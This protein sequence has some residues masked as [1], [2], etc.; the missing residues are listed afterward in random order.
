MTNYVP[1]SGESQF[2]LNDLTEEHSSPEALHITTEPLKYDQSR[3]SGRIAVGGVCFSILFSL[4]CIVAGIFI[5]AHQIPVDQIILLPSSLSHPPTIF[6]GLFV[7]FRRQSSTKRELLGLVLNIAVT[8]CTESIGFV[9]SVALKSALANESRLRFNTNLRLLTAARTNN[10]HGWLRSI[11]FN[12]TSLN[13]VMAILLV[14]SYVCSSLVILP[15]QPEPGYEPSGVFVDPGNSS[16]ILGA[17]LVILGIAL[18][19]Q[20]IIA[21][22]G[23]YRTTILTWS[24][25]P[26]DITTALIDHELLTRYPNRCM[27]SVRHYNTEDGPRKPCLRQH[28]AWEAHPSVRKIVILLWSLIPACAVWGGIA[29]VVAI[30]SGALRN[31]EQQLQSTLGSWAFLPNAQTHELAFT[32]GG[33]E[34]FFS[35]FGALATIATIQ[36]V[37]TIGLHCSEVIVNVV[38]DET[39]WRKASS[40]TGLYPSSNPLAS[41][42]GNWPNVGLLMAKPILRKWLCSLSRSP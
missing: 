31:A 27:H 18:L 35:W 12:G 30:K 11:H 7:I 25:S 3:L 21:L 5:S 4:S 32:L 17:P 9:H 26:F 2:E 37:L 10:T 14:L 20:S 41:V 34:S 19:L 40:K 33:D 22:G 15:F 39:A 38:R 42:L 16:W 13:I 28:S 6:V 23:A 8:I 29:F 24:S 1:V 36:G